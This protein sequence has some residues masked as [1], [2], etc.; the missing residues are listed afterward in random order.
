MLYRLVKDDYVFIRKGISLEQAF[1]IGFITFWVSLFFS[2]F[3][4][5]IFHFNQQQNI[6]VQFF[7]LKSGQFS[8]I[9]AII[10]A[11][12]ALFIFSK[13]KK[14]PLGRMSDFFSLSFLYALPVGLLAF[15]FFVPQN[16]LL[17]HFLN[18]IIYFVV[19]IFFAQFLYPKILNRTIKE[20][21]LTNLFLIIFSLITLTTALLTTLKQLQ[22]FFSLENGFCILLFLLSIIFLIKQNASS[23]RRSVV[24]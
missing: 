13:Q 8:L 19:L 11:A 7:T 17:Y 23:S 18:V 5:L 21:L 15:S 9:G 10:G 4:Y 16:Q 6:F 2:R 22:A 1:D 12:I 14:F 24:R 20:G 3:F